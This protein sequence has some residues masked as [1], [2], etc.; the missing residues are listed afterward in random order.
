MV[1]IYLID[2]LLPLECKVYEHKNNVL[3]FSFVVVSISR[4]VSPPYDFSVPLPE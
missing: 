3:F 1:F 4:I 2:F